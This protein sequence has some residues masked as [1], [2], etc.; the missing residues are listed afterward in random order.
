MLVQLVRIGQPKA[1]VEFLAACSGYFH[2][3]WGWHEIKAFIMKQIVACGIR[4]STG[5]NN[6][7]NDEYHSAALVS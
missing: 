5:V 2:D 1:G 7:I 6:K 3:F 4:K